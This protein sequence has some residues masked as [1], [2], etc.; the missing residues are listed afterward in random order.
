[1]AQVAECLP[2]KCKA[3]SSNTINAKKNSRTQEVTIDGVM[4]YLFQKAR[5]KDFESFIT[6]E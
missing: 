5:R 6:K 1:M 2:S 4:Y 3:L